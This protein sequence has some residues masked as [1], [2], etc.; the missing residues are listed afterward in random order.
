[1]LMTE[2]APGSRQ[3][4][5]WRERVKP[6]V[7]FDVIGSRCSTAARVPLRS[8][9]PGTSVFERTA[10]LG[11]LR[12]ILAVAGWWRTGRRGGA[13]HAHSMRADWQAPPPHPRFGSEN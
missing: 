11:N 10:N 5:P 3:I 7:S 2:A 4:G 9:Q 13:R 12:A 1:M 6:H 8:P